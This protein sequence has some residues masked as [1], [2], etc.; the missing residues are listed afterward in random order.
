MN[1]AQTTETDIQIVRLDPRFD[2]LFP[3]GAKLEKVADG[4]TW[5]EGPAWNRQGN[6]LLFSEIPSNSIYK[7]VEGHGSSLF[8]RP[9]GY[10]GSQPFTGQEPGSNG[11]TFDSAG[12]L[13]MCQH[14]DR[15]IARREPDSKLTVLADR[16]EGKRLNS[17]NDL[18]FKSNGDLYFTD[19][20]FGLPKAFDD[21]GKELPFQGV[22]RIGKNGKLTLLT[23]EV[24]AP[25][26]IGFSPD[27]KT[28]YIS[29]ADRA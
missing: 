18:V 1:A 26:G 11:L 28:L 9:S 29:N 25:N 6:F 13:V 17:P 3:P 23:K 22:Y 19:P 7:W 27:E 8:L 12:R 20:P 24:R 5:V 16:F 21:P 2:R 14:G 15:R 4:F 10:S